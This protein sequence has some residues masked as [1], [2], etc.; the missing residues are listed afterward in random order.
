MKTIRSRFIHCL[1]VAVVLGPWPSISWAAPDPNNS[2]A[3]LEN[4][5]NGAVPDDTLQNE[6]SP[7]SDS[8]ED[9]RWKFRGMFSSS[10]S[11]NLQHPADGINAL[12]GYDFSDRK[13]KLD[14]L[15]LS[16]E[17]GL[18]QSQ[19]VGGR[20]DL[21]GGSSMPRVDAASGLF[22]DPNTGISSTDFDIRQAYL[23]YG[24]DNQLRVDVGKFATIFGFEVMDGVDGINHRNFAFLAA[25]GS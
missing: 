10:Y 22:R 18:E 17:Y 1:L 9:T 7:A 20:L 3:S 25:S 8:P 23:S 21:T 24:F 13:L 2:Q 19:L 16:L 5:P 11:V 6:T 14:V 15:N 12:R 4:P